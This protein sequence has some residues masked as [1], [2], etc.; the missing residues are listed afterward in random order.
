MKNLYLIKRPIYIGKSF[1]IIRFILSSIILLNIFNIGAVS[2]S[3]VTVNIKGKITSATCSVSSDSIN[4]SVD[5]GKHPIGIL[6]KSG[7]SSPAVAFTINLENCGTISR[8]VQVTFTG[9][10]DPLMSD[11]FATSSSGIAIKLMDD[12]KETI[13]AGDTTK[14]YL[15]AEGQTTKS[16]VFYAQM[17]A[18]GGNVVLGKIS[19]NITFDTFYP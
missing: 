7:Q 17:T 16:L 13:S 5:L 15:I 14:A 2:A 19:S 3:D 8:G 4:K 10:P 9:T 11:L 1:N 12:T 6:S 18:T